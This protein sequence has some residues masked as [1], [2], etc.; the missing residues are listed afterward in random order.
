[1]ILAKNMNALAY[2]LSSDE[3]YLEAHFNP[4]S[5][6]LENGCQ[7]LDYLSLLRYSDASN[8]HMPVGVLPLQD[9]RSNWSTP[10]DCGRALVSTKTSI[11][12][13]GNPERAMQRCLIYNRLSDPTHLRVL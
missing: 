13:D 9:C 10:T 7:P 11:C 3:A 5:C 8:S 6:S 12:F 2:R 1:M 4:N